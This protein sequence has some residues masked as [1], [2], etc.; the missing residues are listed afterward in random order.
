MFIDLLDN[1]IIII[2]FRPVVVASLNLISSRKFVGYAAAGVFLLQKIQ[3]RGTND[4]LKITDTE[5]A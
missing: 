1:N 5:L 4:G 3:K 2:L